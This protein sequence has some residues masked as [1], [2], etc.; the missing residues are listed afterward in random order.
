M[1]FC[2]VL[3]SLLTDVARSYHSAGAICI[4]R[5]DMGITWASTGSIGFFTP[6]RCATSPRVGSRTT[7]SSFSACPET[8]NRSTTQ[9]SRRRSNGRVLHTTPSSSGDDIFYEDFVEG[10]R[11]DCME[12]LALGDTWS[13]VISTC[14]RCNGLEQRLVRLFV[15]M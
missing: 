15:L 4:N 8:A 3:T 9:R 14:Q 5:T 13:G 7:T 12:E 11:A 2:V 6:V 10:A 1:L